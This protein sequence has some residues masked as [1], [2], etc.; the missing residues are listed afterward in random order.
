MLGPMPLSR[1]QF[2]RRFWSPGDEPTPERLAR[3]A[4]L[5]TYTR[6][7]LLPYDFT[8]TADQ[9]AQLIAAVRAALEKASNDELF[10]NVIHARIEEATEAKLQPWRERSHLAA[11]ADRLQE[12][13]QAAPDYVA[14]FFAVQASAATIERFQ[15]IYGVDDRAELENLLKE[16]VRLWIAEVDD[17][18]IA[19]YDII[20]IQ[21]LVFAQLRS[22]C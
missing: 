13:R 1:R 20:A 5:E 9:E 16:Q 19:Q 8:L 2:F 15:E 4:A 6:T 12:V 14:R 7:Q 22:W 3:Y 21:D 18:L 17:R 11:Q 10:S